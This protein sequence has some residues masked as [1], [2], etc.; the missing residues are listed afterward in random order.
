MFTLH[1]S[2]RC[3]ARAPDRELRPR[4]HDAGGWG[5]REAGSNSR[6]ALSIDTTLRAVLVFSSGSAR[7]VQFAM[8]QVGL[9]EGL[10]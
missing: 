9:S 1:I 2:E 6:R 5:T 8:S 10:E 4:G 3:D 7:N